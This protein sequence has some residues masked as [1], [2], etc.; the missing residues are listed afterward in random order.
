MLP[1]RL[2]SNL[3]NIYRT[4]QSKAAEYTFFLSAPKYMWN[5]LHDRLYVR[6]QNNFHEFKIKIMS[7]I[8]SHHNGLKIENNY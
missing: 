1:T 3:M 2:I 8:F 4:L 7:S 5:I 6:P